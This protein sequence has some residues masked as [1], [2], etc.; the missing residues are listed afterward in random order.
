[1]TRI[2]KLIQYIDEHGKESFLQQALAEEYIKVN[3]DD[4]ARN[5]LND[6]LLREPTYISAYIHLGNI[7]V[8]VGDEAK[9]IRIFSRGIAEATKAKNN[10]IIAE[11][12]EALE[13]II[14]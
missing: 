3:N 5:V 9:A 4:A 8:R 6:L 1:M 2:E 13:E 10:T 7:L 11:L 12:Q 14:Y